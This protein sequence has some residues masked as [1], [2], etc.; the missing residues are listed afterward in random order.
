MLNKTKTNQTKILLKHEIHKSHNLKYNYFD[1]SS[2]KLFKICG[3][4]SLGEFQHILL[5]I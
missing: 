3:N 4:K 5:L 2:T 1:Y